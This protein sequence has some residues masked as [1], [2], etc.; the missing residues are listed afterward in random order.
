LLVGRVLDGLLHHLQGVHLLAQPGNLLLQ[1]D[2][3]GLGDIALFAVGAVQRSQ[4]TRDAGV[5]LFDPPGDPWRLCNSG[6]GCSRSDPAA[7]WLA[8]IPGIGVLNATALVA[9]IGDGQSFARGRDLAAWLGLVPRQ[10]TTGADRGLWASPNEAA[11]T[12]A[13]C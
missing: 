12:S 7:R 3:L 6:R 2:R 4:I 9:A 1:P 5:D 11:N 13:S 10:V 8:T